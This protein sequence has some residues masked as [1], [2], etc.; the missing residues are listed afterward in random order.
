MCIN[1]TSSLAASAGRNLR[2]ELLNRSEGDVMTVIANMDDNME[3]E[4]LTIQAIGVLRGI[5]QRQN[6]QACLYAARYELVHNRA[7]HISPE[8]QPQVNE[9]IH[10][11]STLLPHLCKKLLKKTLREA[12]DVTMEFEPELDFAVMETCFEEPVI[13][14]TFTTEE[15]QTRSQTQKQNQNQQGSQPQF[16]KQQY[17]GQ[18]NFQRNQNQ[19]KSGYGSGY[20]SQYNKGNN[21]Y[22]GNQ[23]QYQGQQQPGANQTPECQPRIDFG[24]VIPTSQFGLEQFIKM[25][26]ALKWVEDKYKMPP[27]QQQNKHDQSSGGNNSNKENQLPNNLTQLTSQ[28][29]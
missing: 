28:P 16:Q 27:N 5:Q 14:E 12:M 18:K 22:D 3:D 9:I 1:Q 8:E 15:V 20:K 26:K 4:D 24:M 6:E 19:N 11:A 7:N 25:T 29:S 17:M 2:L 13:E 10:Y 23:S 21:Q